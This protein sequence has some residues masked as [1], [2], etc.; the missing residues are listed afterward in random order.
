MSAETTLRAAR[1]DDAA[2]TH[3]VRNA[4]QIRATSLDTRE[5]ALGD[6][7]AWW[8]AALVDPDRGLWVIVH[9]AE[10]AG[11]L[12]LD[13]RGDVAE[14]SI[15]L[16]PGISGRGIGRHA[17]ALAVPLARERWGVARVE[18]TIREENVASQR[19]FAAAGFVRDGRGWAR[20][21]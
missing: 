18:A 6:H 4:P 17:I 3:A 21:T 13:R 11:V 9:G 20:A 19:A 1:D 10:D 2:W 7:V 5:I 14:I 12:R 16:R 8:R 15:Y